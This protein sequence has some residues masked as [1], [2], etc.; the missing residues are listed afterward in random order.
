MIVDSSSEAIELRAPVT[1]SRSVTG[2]R[3]CNQLVPWDE[4]S[5]ISCARSFA[6][7][8]KGEILVD[9]GDGGAQA[10]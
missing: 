1:H 3:T 10:S 6:A 4:T 2:A 8:S 7:C 9:T 5:D